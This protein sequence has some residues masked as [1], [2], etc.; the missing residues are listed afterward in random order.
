MIKLK[1]RDEIEIMKEGGKI[2]KS[3]ADELMPWI[4][5]GMSTLQIDQKA[6]TLIKQHS[7]EPSFKTVKG[8]NWT[9]CIPVNEQ[10]VHT[11]PSERKIE[12]GDVVT[13]DVGVLLKGYHTDYAYTRLMGQENDTEKKRFLDAGRITLESAIKM[14]HQGAYLGTIGE[15]IHN[16]I[17]K[18]GYFI[19]KELTGHGIGKSL[20]EDPYVLNYL[21][22]PVHKTY[23]I[24]SGFVFALEII[25]SMGS[26]ELAYEQGN[27]W[28]I[29]T[30]DGS[31]AACFEKT[32]AV[33]DEKTFILT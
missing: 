20:H 27:S 28:S 1:T 29:N 2:L 4:E 6:E 22:K 30:R 19:M 8:Y 26:E 31:L 33:I 23:K 24:E 18:N 15:F 11:P 7:A 9:T 14:V 32:L 13:V 5:V 25:Y 10:A 17:T 16:E 12:E 3:V 21:D